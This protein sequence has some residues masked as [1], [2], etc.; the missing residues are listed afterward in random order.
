M[1]LSRRNPQVASSSPDVNLTDWHEIT[2]DPLP[3][4]LD[5]IGFV[6]WHVPFRGR[7]WFT[8]GF[9]YWTN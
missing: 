5:A 4:K 8:M 9:T 2:F 1:P 7:T 6:F 3:A